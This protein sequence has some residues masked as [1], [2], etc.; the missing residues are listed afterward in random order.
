MIVLR[1]VLFNIYF[2]LWILLVGGPTLPL[3]LGPRRFMRWIPMLWSRGVLWG[4][5]WIVGLTWEVRGR[6]HLTAGPV[7]IASKHQSAWETI[8]F[9]AVLDDPVYVLK[10]ELLRIPLFGWY[11]SKNGMIG[12]DR[13]AGAAA[14]IKMARESKDALNDGRALVIFPEGTR[15][16][17]GEEGRWKPGVAALYRDLQAP[18][19]GM[20]LNSGMFWPRGG[21]IKKPGRIIVEILPPIPPGLERRKFLH[22]LS[23]TVEAATRRLEQEATAATEMQ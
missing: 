16:P 19:Y 7:V 12:V 17:A 6:E 10:Q 13:D 5:K 21:W 23:L 9:I 1:S 4:L 11:A 20:A 18:V 14:L 8:A 15:T 2:Y 3:L 22:E